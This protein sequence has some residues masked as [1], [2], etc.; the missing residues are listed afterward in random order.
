MYA[1]KFNLTSLA[2]ALLGVFLLTLY[3]FSMPPDI[4]FEDTP[5]FA[6]TCVKLGLAHPPGYPLYTFTCKPFT[7]LAE[8]LPISLG[9][10]VALASAVAA[11]GTCVVLAGLL[12]RL[13]GVPAA[14]VLAAALLGLAPT[15]WGQAQIPEIYALNALLVV[16]TLAV[17]HHYVAGGT[18]WCL[19]VGS[20]LVG[21]GLANH[22]PLYVIVGPAFVLWLAPAAA[23]VYSDL[24]VPQVLGAIV[25]A[26]ALGL[27]PYLHFLTVA[28]E[29]LFFDPV[30]NWDEFV[31][32]VRRDVYLIRPN[33]IELHSRLL[34]AAWSATWFISQFQYVFGV[35]ALVGL[36]L[37]VQAR[38]WWRLAA[39]LWGMLS[40]TTLLALIRPFS[41]VEERS[42]WIFS[43]YP[44]PAYV[45]V[46]IPLAMALAWL[47][48]RLST[49][50]QMAG[51]VLAI[52][53]IVFIRFPAMDRR[54]EDFAFP[55]SI[56]LLESLPEDSILINRAGDY[57]FA[58]RYAQLVYGLRPDIEN[59]LER[60]FFSADIFSGILIPEDEAL[61]VQQDKPVTFVQALQ[62]KTIGSIYL[63]THYLVDPDLSPGITVIRIPSAYRDLLRS[64]LA[65]V[66]DAKP[67]QFNVFFLEQRIIE[68]VSQITHAKAAGQQIDPED[69]QLLLEIFVTPLG[70]YARFIA[71]T[72]DPSRVD[73]TRSEINSL[74]QTVAPYMPAMRGQQRSDI[75]HIIAT[76]HI[77]SGDLTEGLEMLQ[78]S[79]REY[80]TSGNRKV[81][82]DLL[83]VHAKLGQ[84]DAYAKLRQKYS[85]LDSG[86]ALVTP[87]TECAAALLQPCEP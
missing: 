55:L 65:Y 8:V 75:L 69:T 66:Q 5:L 59:V 19:P 11:A 74:A 87:D 16:L 81:L 18:R 84:F 40:S 49:T 43:V 42:T 78:A 38:N 14:A 73:L 25:L 12:I 64:M 30:K 62:L 13:T 35:L 77:L 23:R 70:Q 82:I 85:K 47:T 44:I 54:T 21:L 79:F 36:V 58:F 45:F 1:L 33:T 9:Q 3:W 17:V 50:L 51:V 48:R 10:S 68:Y 57:A 24:K 34:G 31:S 71:W 29:D 67:N 27:S 2:L 60:N 83:Q 26:L 39:V 37:L 61:L 32:Y 4:T 28:P 53:V 72:L 52:A 6:S 15:F 76:A 22:W 41:H 20:L 63:G 7:L 56:L 80:P 46:T 86:T